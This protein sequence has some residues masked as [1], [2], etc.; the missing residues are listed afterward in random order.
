[1]KC[2][3]NQKF[4]ESFHAKF[5]SA[6]VRYTK[7]QEFLNLK[8]GDMTMEQYDV[9]FDMLSRFALEI[10]KDRATRTEKFVRG[11]RLDLQG[12]VRALRPATHADALRLALDMSLHE[13]ANPSK[14]TGRGLTPVQKKKAEL[15]PIVAPQRNLRSGGLFQRHRQELA[16]VGRTLREL[17]VCRSCGRSR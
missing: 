14:A 7:Q 10:V 13:R 3:D 9:E 2:P 17:P 4:K 16:A 8:Q 11:L 15:Q 1:M 5:F 12:F 6:N